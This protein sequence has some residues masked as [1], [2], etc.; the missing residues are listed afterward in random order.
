MDS[1]LSGLTII[2]I[3]GGVATRYCGHLFA[4]HGA[5]VLQLG[6]PSDTAVGYGGAGSAAYASWLDSGKQRIGS[7]ADAAKHRITL[8]IAGQDAASVGA[9]DAA[10]RSAGLDGAIRLGLTWFAPDGPYRDWIGNDGVIQA[11]SAV[12]YA[13]GAKDG[14]PM[15]PRGH[16]PQAIAGATAFIAAMGALLGRQNGWEGRTIDVNI[17]EA[18]LCLSESGAASVALTGDR[19]VRRGVNRFTPT[20]PGGIYAAS[21]GWIGVTALTPPQW[22]SLCDMI[23]HSELARNP[24]HLVSL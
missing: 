10:I 5:T 19:T 24:A 9:A 8:V 21:D 20:F 6:K 1:A 15:L 16:A 7:Y 2:E 13:T 4:A 11:M 17:L 22:R 23:G 14:A 18:N 12:S 3:P